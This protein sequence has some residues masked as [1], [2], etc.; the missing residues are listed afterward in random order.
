MPTG[1]CGECWKPAANAAMDWYAVSGDPAAFEQLYDLLAPRL[2][3]FLLRRTRNAARADDL[4]QQTFLQMHCA[5]RHFAAGG[6]VMPW[7][8]AIARRLLIDGF[9]KGVRECLADDADERVDERCE[10][11]TPDVVVAHR[12]LAARMRE[13]LERLPEAHRVAF[14]LI[15][16]DGL[17]VAEAAQVLGTTAAAVKLR[18]YEALRERLGDVVREELGVV[19]P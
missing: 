2:R 18:A 4:M 10:R 9:R 14:D 6:E 17:S 5:R 11:D 3:V 7:A 19:P 16:G 1:A 13:E 8:F 15:Q 12:R